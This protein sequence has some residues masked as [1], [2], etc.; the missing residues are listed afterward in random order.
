MVSAQSY[1]RTQHELA[2]LRLLA[3]GEVE[4]EAGAG[5]DLDTVLAESDK[6][7]VI[8]DIRRAEEQ[9]DAGMGIPHEVVEKRLRKRY[10]K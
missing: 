4:I 1:E 6:L 2:I 8:H 3:R 9:L 7:A 5:H 10:L